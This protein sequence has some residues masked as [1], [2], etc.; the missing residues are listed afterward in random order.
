MDERDL[1]QRGRMK[2][3]VYLTLTNKDEKLIKSNKFD[4]ER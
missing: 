4:N 3:T 2:G 1:A